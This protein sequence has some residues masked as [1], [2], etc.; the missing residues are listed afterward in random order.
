MTMTLTRR[1]KSITR[2]KRGSLLVRGLEWAGFKYSRMLLYQRA[3]DGD[4][5]SVEPV[6]TKK[7]NRVHANATDLLPEPVNPDKAQSSD[8]VI[9]L[10]DGDDCLGYLWLSNRSSYY[11]S[12]LNRKMTIPDAYVWKVFV[13]PKYRKE[14]VG[15][16]LLKQTVRIAHNHGYN[17]LSALVAANN[18]PSRYLFE[19]VGFSPETEHRYLQIVDYEYRMDVNRE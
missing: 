14:G 8:E 9:T 12:P 17:S 13:C 15:T 3:L 11:I 6:R 16:E 1:I 4:P 19:K 18:F 5:P 2:G 7:V 10:S